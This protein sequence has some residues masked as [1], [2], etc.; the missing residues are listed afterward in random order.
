MYHVGNVYLGKMYRRLER[1]LY[2]RKV[3]GAQSL[4]FS[5]PQERLWASSYK[6]Q[7]TRKCSYGLISAF[8]TSNCKD[9]GRLANVQA[10]CGMDLA[11][12]VILVQRQEVGE[13][14]V[15]FHVIINKPRRYLEVT[16][17]LWSRFLGSCEVRRRGILEMRVLI[18]HIAFQLLGDAE[19]KGPAA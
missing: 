13:S 1:A 6:P 2:E 12:V 3:I 8:L 16:F 7:K 17:I 5:R 18:E 4:E 15:S 11:W 9:M 19:G 14:P 10:K